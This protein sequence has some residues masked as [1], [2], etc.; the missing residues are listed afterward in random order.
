HRRRD[1]GRGRVLRDVA[2]FG[3]RYDDLFDP[4]GLQRGDL[5]LADQR[6]LFQDEA[7]LAN[8][9]HRD[10]SLGFTH[11]HRAELH[12]LFSGG[13]RS[14]AVIS[15]MIATAISDGDTAPIA[16]PIGAWM[17]ASAPS[18][19]PCALSRSMRRACVFFEPNAPI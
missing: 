17:R 2:R 14:S 8:R 16:S 6:A 10:G 11:W 19:K 15:P 12:E 13:S 4:G 1:F 9:V 7:A 18:D 5:V 3:P